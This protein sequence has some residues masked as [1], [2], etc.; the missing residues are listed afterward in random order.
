[1][2]MGISMSNERPA[3]ID[4]LFATLEVLIWLVVCWIASMLLDGELFRLFYDFW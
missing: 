4:I 3:L 2:R 1:M